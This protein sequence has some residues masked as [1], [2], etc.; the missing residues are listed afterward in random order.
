[1][2]IIDLPEGSTLITDKNLNGFYGR[3]LSKI[4]KGHYYKI[5]NDDILCLDCEDDDEDDDNEEE[6]DDDDDDDDDENEK[7]Q[8]HDITVQ[9]NE[10][11][12][13]IEVNDNSDN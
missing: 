10:N 6:E 5:L 9:F 3:I 8:K 12:V 13:D 1:M 7:E 11:G 2:V 4:K